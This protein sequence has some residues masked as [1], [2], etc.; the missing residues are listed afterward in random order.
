MRAWRA[1]KKGFSLAAGDPGRCNICTYDGPLLDK[2]PY[3]Q[4][5]RCKSSNRHRLICWTLLNDSPFLHAPGARVLH[6]APE[7]SLGAL[8]RAWP[9]L[10]YETADLAA[11]G[12]THNF[13][14]APLTATRIDGAGHAGPG[15][16]AELLPHRPGRR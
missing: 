4:C 14:L 2:P 11:Q 10:R 7:L 1:V 5:P 16:S 6:F 8:F 9:S 12:V 15:T 13:D 3:L